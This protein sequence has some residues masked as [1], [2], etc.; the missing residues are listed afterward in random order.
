MRNRLTIDIK[1]FFTLRSL[2]VSQTKEEHLDRLVMCDELDVKLQK[3]NL[4]H[5]TA[6]LRQFLVSRN[7]W[8]K[9]KSCLGPGLQP[10]KDRRERRMAGKL[11]KFSLDA[12]NRDF[13]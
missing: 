6:L 12:Q 7:S 10:T 13:R 9:K 1:Y 2:G 5:R 3:N 11:K 4:I 8:A